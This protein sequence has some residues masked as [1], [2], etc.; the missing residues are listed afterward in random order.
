[1][2]VT[3]PSFAAGPR[4]FVYLTFGVFA[5]VALSIVNLRRS[6]TGLAPN[7]VRWSTTGSKTMGISVVN[8]KVLVARIAAFVAGIGGAMYAMS[9]GVAMPNDQQ[10]SGGW[11]G[12][13]S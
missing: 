3:P 2:K 6:T 8:M 5:I 12:L 9:L 7:A 1:V 4:A 13:P 10:P 11:S